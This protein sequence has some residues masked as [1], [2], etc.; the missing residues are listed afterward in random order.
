MSNDVINA[1]HVGLDGCPLGLGAERQ[2]GIRRKK[3][4]QNV[5]ESVT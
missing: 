4:K 5:L 3:Q 2:H 1:L